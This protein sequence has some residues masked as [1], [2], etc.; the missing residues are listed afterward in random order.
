MG[1]KILPDI[2]ENIKGLMIQENNLKV[3]AN[4]RLK[5]CRI[6]IS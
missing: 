2:G 5:C 6:I 1:Q 3:A 4:F